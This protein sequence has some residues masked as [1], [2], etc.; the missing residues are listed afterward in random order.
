[1]SLILG[2]IG[3]RSAG[4]DTLA[5]YLIDR[6]GAF[7]ISHSRILDQILNILDLPI[8]RRNEID[9]GMALRGP[10]GEGVIA[11]A[12]RKQVLAAPNRVKVVQSIRF[13]HEVKNVRSLGGRIIFIEAPLSVRYQRAQKR[14]E[15]TD[16]NI[17]FEQF[18]AMQ[19]EPTEIG[20]ADLKEQADIVLGNQGTVEEF[21][22]QIDDMMKQ[23]NK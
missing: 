19:R 11:Q 18:Q 5:Q 15:K 22:R 21:Y 23:L 10:F 12:L 3:E 2:V 14:R 6:Y 17:S 20:I 8:S 7:A 4:K 1:M 13:P 9:L 16:D